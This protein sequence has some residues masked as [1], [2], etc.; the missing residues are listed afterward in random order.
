MQKLYN[1]IDQAY[2]N[3]KEKLTLVIDHLKSQQK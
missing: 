2:Q 3:R 1:T